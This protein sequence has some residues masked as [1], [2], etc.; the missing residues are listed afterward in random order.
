MARCN[1][2]LLASKKSEEDFRKFS[3]EESEKAKANIDLLQE[4][5]KAINQEFNDSNVKWTAEREKLKAFGDE[6]YQKL[7]NVNSQLH[8][9]EE[10]SGV[11]ESEQLQRVCSLQVENETLKMQMAQKVHIYLYQFFHFVNFENFD[12]LI[13]FD[14]PLLMIG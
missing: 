1:E 5:I 9:L 8:A 2:E 11:S 3:M 12:K 4:K 6:Q 7:N 13:L 14:F 10:N